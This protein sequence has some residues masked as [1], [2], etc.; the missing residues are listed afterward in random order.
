MWQLCFESYVSH[1]NLDEIS[2]FWFRHLQ[3]H[4]HIIG[5]S[6]EDS[7]SL[8]SQNDAYDQECMDKFGT[9]LK[10]IK[11]LEPDGADIVAAAKPCKLMH[12][13]SLIILLH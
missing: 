9:L 1:A 2:T 3:D 6:I 11:V 12:W 4:D 8:F 7:A 5:P 13:I 10:L